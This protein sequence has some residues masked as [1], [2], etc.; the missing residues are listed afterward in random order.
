MHKLVTKI[1]LF[2]KKHT[3]AQ[4]KQAKGNKYYVSQKENC[5]TRIYIK[6]LCFSCRNTHTHAHRVAVG[7]KV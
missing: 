7:Q 1:N 5:T 4:G 3:G 2:L 6:T